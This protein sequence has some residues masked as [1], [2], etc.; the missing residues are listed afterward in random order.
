MDGQRMTYSRRTL[1]AIGE[2]F[3]ESATQVKAGGYGRI[4]GGGGDIISDTFGGIGD[5]LSGAVSSVEDLGQGILNGVNDFGVQIDQS[6]RDA[7]PGGWMS[8]ASMAA[9]PYLGPMGMAG[10]GAVGGSG[11][12]QG[13][14][15][16]LMG[17]I[18]GGATAYGLAS[19]GEGL[20]DAGGGVNPDVPNPEAPPTY[21]PKETTWTPTP[22]GVDP[23]PPEGG[24]S[25]PSTIEGGAPE[26]I[27][28]NP[29]TK[30]PEGI[31]PET[32]TPYQPNPT[33]TSPYNKLASGDVS[34][35]ASQYGHDLAARASSVGEGIKNLSGFGADGAQ[36]A[37]YDALTKEFGYK[38][39]GAL[40]GGI[41]GTQAMDQ[42]KQQADEQLAQGKISQA[43][44]DKTVAQIEENRQ[45]AVA[46]V[47]QSPF[48]KILPYA[49]TNPTA[50][51]STY[52]K[53]TTGNLYGGTTNKLYAEGGIASLSDINTPETLMAGG[54]TNDFHFV[55]GGM[56]GVPRFLSGG[57]D[58]M[59][60]SIKASIDG[61][62]EARLADGEFVIPADVVSHLGNGSS[63][64]G[65]KQL[66]SMMDRVRKARTG[67]PKQGKQINPNKFT[68]V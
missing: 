41:A 44:Y 52:A 36:S 29:N 64:A 37:A 20:S 2:P 10:L 1:Y 28:V 63:K 57:G 45:K 59:S 21:D 9:S 15:F 43:E 30:V 17:A 47:K 12:L 8:L 27:S 4:Y 32:G 31:N 53:N 50:S 68:P 13:K 61:N 6:V 51:K 25:R 48:E 3:G 42:A 58:G 67:N 16:N 60:D 11:V 24:W 19:L 34:G 40:V 38:Q 33:N 54:I 39:A 46:A 66:Y 5:A 14:K 22:Q 49:P 62:Q 7:V 23:I 56:T 18:T 26:P 65:A 35:A 55:H